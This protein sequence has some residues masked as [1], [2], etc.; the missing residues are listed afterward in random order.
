MSKGTLHQISIIGRVGKDPEPRTTPKGDP[1]CEFSVAVNDLEF[2][3]GAPNP[4]SIWYKVRINGKSCQAAAD[5]IRKGTQIFVQG[6]P[7]CWAFAD[8]TT[9]APRASI[10][11]RAT[12]WE[13]LG[14]PRENDHN[15]A[16]NSE[17]RTAPNNMNFDDDIPGF[18]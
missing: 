8:K 11:I 15:S 4:I 18:N 10:S 2:K 14:S 7:S 3:D 12:A 17:Q 13:L 16:S 6:I 1:V 9:G 5:Y